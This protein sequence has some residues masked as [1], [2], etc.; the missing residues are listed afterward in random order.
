[1][2]KKIT[3]WENKDGCNKKYR[4]ATEL[5]SL[6]MLSYAYIIVNYCGVGAPV[7]GKYVVYCLNDNDNFFLTMLIENYATSWCSHK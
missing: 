5:Y 6:D 7:H 1:M 4:C 2:T 3:I